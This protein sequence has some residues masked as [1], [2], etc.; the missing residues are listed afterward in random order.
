V[1]LFPRKIFFSITTEELIILGASWSAFFSLFLGIKSPGEQDSGFYC[2]TQSLA[3]LA[4]RITPKTWMDEFCKV[5][6]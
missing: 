4:G 3:S 1:R 6:N 2:V 5:A